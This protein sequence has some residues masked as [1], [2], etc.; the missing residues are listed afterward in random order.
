MSVIHKFFKRWHT[1]LHI[2]KLDDMSVGR[3]EYYETVT[4]WKWKCVLCGH[5]ICQYTNAAL[6]L[7]D[8]GKRTGQIFIWLNDRYKKE[9]E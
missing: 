5:E 1:H 2:I 6:E 4:G 8:E 7:I 3:G 9:S